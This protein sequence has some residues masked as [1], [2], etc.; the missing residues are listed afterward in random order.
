MS[1]NSLALGV[2]AVLFM[3]C[4][5]ART[6]MFSCVKNTATSP[7]LASPENMDA[8][9]PAHS[10]T[11]TR[12]ESNHVE[13]QD[14]TRKRSSES[15]DV[16]CRLKERRLQ[17]FYKEQM[18]IKMKNGG[19]EA[20]LK[21]DEV[22]SDLSTKYS[23]SPRSISARSSPCDYGSP[24]T[25]SLQQKL[26]S[27]SDLTSSKLSAIEERIQYKENLKEE[28]FSNFPKNCDIITNNVEVKT[29]QVEEQQPG[30]EQNGGAGG[31]KM[32]SHEDDDVQIL[33]ENKPIFTKNDSNNNNGV[34][35]DEATPAA[36][37][38]GCEDCGKCFS[39]RQLLVQHRRIHTGER[40]YSCADCGRQFTQRGH[41]STH[42]KLHEPA[43]RPEHACPSC[44]K[45]FVTRAS[46]KVHLRTHTG[47]KPFQCGE[48]GKQFS[49]LRNYKYHRSVHE[50]TREFAATCPECGK[51]FN[52]R[53]YLSS[54]MKI[55]RNRKEYGCQYCGKSFNQRVAYN[56]H[57]GFLKTRHFRMQQDPQKIGL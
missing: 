6:G 35:V 33:N 48:C 23:Q 24:L 22:A 45:A 55:H 40:P 27:L 15:L 47:E 11:Q 53:G 1:R 46:L 30:N 36:K 10:K 39:R 14:P 26:K 17:E 12:P 34:V 54:H 9:L 28:D 57:R 7:F 5:L 51:Y 13:H 49:Q 43:R 42:Q 32:Y 18:T 41:W 8:S 31:G 4:T 29:E 21:D 3:H 56:M 19:N 52:D 20:S 25:P 44:G 50:G 38:H 2:F 37:N 16:F